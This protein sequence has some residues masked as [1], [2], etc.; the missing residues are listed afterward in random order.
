MDYLHI[1]RISLIFAKFRKSEMGVATVTFPQGLE[2]S[3]F[4]L[5]YYRPIRGN[6]WGKTFVI[7]FFQVDPKICLT[8]P[9]YIWDQYLR[10]LYNWVST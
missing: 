2:L 1:I 5:R 3:N 9:Y 4:F 10:D 7:N 6:W 8:F